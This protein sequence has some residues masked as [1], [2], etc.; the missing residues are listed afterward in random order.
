VTPAWRAELLSGTVLATPLFLGAVTHG[1]CIRFGLLRRLAL[2]LDR[3]A[4]FRGQR[5]F[6]DNKTWRGIVAVA[7][8]SALGFLLLGIP[9]RA[10]ALPFG[11][12]VGAAA[13]LAE[14]PNSFVKRRLAIAPGRQAGGVRG[15]FF[16]LLDQV[17]VVAGA[18]LV[19]A[20][21]VRP[22]VARVS[23]FLI[24]VALVHPLLTAAGYALGMRAT[25][26]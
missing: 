17:D 16:Q 7:L 15:A 6:G 18:W 23:G 20:F 21:A 9:S 5:L 14:L 8:G 10:S 25:P 19:L 26:R 13:M 12:A 2:P 4:T 24:A 3:G 22:T 1:L 11:L